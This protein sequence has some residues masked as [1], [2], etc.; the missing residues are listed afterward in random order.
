MQTHLIW[1]T[2][3]YYTCYMATWL[4]LLTFFNST[5]CHQFLE[6]S[7]SRSMPCKETSVWENWI[8]EELRTRTWN[9]ATFMYCMPETFPLLKNAFQI[10]NKHSRQPL[11]SSAI[12]LSCNLYRH[13]HRNNYKV[14]WWLLLT[15]SWI[16]FQN[17]SSQI[18]TI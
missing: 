18:V 15:I 12:I 2:I 14:F 7:M 5:N 16:A 17:S 1:M 9:N 10:N 11:F 6:F 13:S 3:W 8:G 4:H